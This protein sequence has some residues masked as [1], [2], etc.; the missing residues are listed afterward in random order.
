MLPWKTVP[1]FKWEPRKEPEVT[2]SQPEGKGGEVSFRTSKEE[3]LKESTRV[4][5]LQRGADIR[6]QDLAL[7]S[8]M[9]PRG[10]ISVESRLQ[11]KSGCGAF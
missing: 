3:D 11:E 4:K 8:S 5:R 2:Q 1:A 9:T 7:R 10:H 6:I